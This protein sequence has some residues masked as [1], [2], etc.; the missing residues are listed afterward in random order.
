MSAPAGDRTARRWGARLM[1]LFISLRVTTV[2]LLLGF[3]ASLLGAIIAQNRDP[4]FYDQKYGRAGAALI[5]VFGLDDAFHTWWYRVLLVAFFAQVLLCT[6][7]RFRTAWVQFAR[8]GAYVPDSGQ[9]TVVVA[10]ELEAVQEEARRLGYR[11][12]AGGAR[13]AGVAPDGG[14]AEEPA[15]AAPGG[16]GAEEPAAAPSPREGGPP[17]KP[18]PIFL[19]RGRLQPLGFILLHVSLLVL[20]T[21][22]AWNL[23]RGFSQ[24]LYLPEGQRV[25]EQRTNRLLELVDLEPRYQQ[26]RHTGDET[27]YELAGMRAVIAVYDGGRRLQEGTLSLGSS[28]TFDRGEVVLQPSLDASQVVFRVTSPQGTA[29]V[30]RLSFAVPQVSLAG[31]E[32]LTLRVVDFARDADRVGSAWRRRTPQLRNPLAAVAVEREQQPG[33]APVELARADLRPGESLSAEG[34][35][36]TFLEAVYMPVV[37][38]SSRSGGPLVLGGI[39]ANL[40][41]VMLALGFSFRQL[42]L[43]PVEGG[44]EVTGYA[45]RRNQPL[46]EELARLAAAA[47]RPVSDERS[48]S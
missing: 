30:E 13:P 22:I 15:G 14:G 43:V 34:Y 2:V 36:I 24:A 38:V 21:G 41:G 32:G 6:I 9:E 45:R 19:A 47:P 48:G 42:R 44:V 10:A 29:V 1:A 12:V 35:T 27:D 18:T 5:R 33:Q 23:S 7:G 20:L 16:G 26:V 28:M 31:G 25:L 40:L 11:P 37:V 4:S 39:A 3:G 8:P 17:A 46:T